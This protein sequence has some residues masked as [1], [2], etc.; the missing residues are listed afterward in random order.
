MKAIFFETS[1]FTTK[2]PEYLTEADYRLLQNFLLN[3]P[4]SGDLM[5]RT[6]GFRKIRWS[7]KRRRKG[8]RG[9][10]RV[11]YCWLEQPHQ[12]WMFTLY[13]KDE[14]EN[15]TPEQEK[16]LKKALAGELRKRGIHDEQE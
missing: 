9:G 6:G 15:L 2:R 8:T 4:K 11:V 13:D 16:Q 1:I 5:P 14:M 7:D 12:F 3:N 10:L